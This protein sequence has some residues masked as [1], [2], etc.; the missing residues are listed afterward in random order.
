MMLVIFSYYRAKDCLLNFKRK[1]DFKQV[2]RTIF[3]LV[4]DFVPFGR[5]MLI[6]NMRCRYSKTQSVLKLVFK[7]LSSVFLY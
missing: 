5:W 1:Y 3:R 4:G 6:K 7:D 2:F